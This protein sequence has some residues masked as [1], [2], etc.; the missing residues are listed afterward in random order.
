MAEKFSGIIARARELLGDEAG[1]Q[2]YSDASLMRHAN[3]ALNVIAVVQPQLFSGL[4]TMACQAGAY[5][6]IPSSWIG[7]V[8]VIGVVGGGALLKADRA[9]LD[10]V[11]SQWMR[12]TPGVP[13]Q[14]AAVAGDE[15]RFLLC[16]PAAEGTQLEVVASAVDQVY[17]LADALPVPDAYAPAIAYFV[18]SMAFGTED[19][20]MNDAKS[21]KY[22]SLFLE[23]IGADQSAQARIREKQAAKRSGVPE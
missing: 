16:P 20:D 19:E 13:T 5:Q 11:D 8:D 2:R 4:K 15:R 7:L 21:Q 18:A 12:R 17:A 10:R 1:V 22:M 9:T 14:W 23:F 3:D 6:F